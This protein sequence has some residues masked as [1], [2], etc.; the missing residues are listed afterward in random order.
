MYMYHCRDKFQANVSVISNRKNNDYLLPQNTQTQTHT[1]A[2]KKEKKRKE[3]KKKEK[4]RKKKEK[5]NR[6]TVN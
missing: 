2:H 5:K 6:Q 4:K 1:H 3:K